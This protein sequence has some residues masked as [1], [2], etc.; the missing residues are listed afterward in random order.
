MDKREENKAG[1]YWGGLY[2]IF[3]KAET[4]FIWEYGKVVVLEDFRGLNDLLAEDGVFLI[5]GRCNSLEFVSEDG[6][7]IYHSDY[8]FESRANMILILDKQIDY[9]FDL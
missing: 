8:N 6:I 3:E 9:N 2:N 5:D 1:G 4:Y 7:V